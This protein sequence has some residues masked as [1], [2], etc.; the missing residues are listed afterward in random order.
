MR[1]FRDA[2]IKEKITLIVMLTAGVALLVTCASFILNDVVTIRRAKVVNLSILADIVGANCTAPLAFNDEKSATETLAA[3][4]ANQTITAACIYDKSGRPFARYARGDAAGVP[5]PDQVGKDGHHF[6][7]SALTLFEPVTLDRERIGTVFLQADLSDIQA[8]L[9]GYAGI[10]TLTLLVSLLVALLIASKLQGLISD[11]I[12]SLAQTASQ[13]STRKDYS[14][15]A[16]KQTNDEIGFLIDRFNE[17]L[18]QIQK[19]EAAL[20]AVNQQLA[21]SEQAALAATRA[22]SGFLANMSHELRTPLNAIIGFSE[23][24]VDKTFGELNTRQN[25]YV[26]NILNSGR[27]L[28]QLINDILDLAKVEAGRLELD[29]SSFSAAEALRSVEA[30]AKA[31]AG[32]KQ[33]M[34]TLEADPDLPTVTADEGKFKQIMFN[35]LSNA[36]KFTPE[37]GSVS[38]SA[39]QEG[40][41]EDGTALSQI[42]SGYVHIAV[43]DSGIGIKPEDQK[44]VFEEFEQLDASY[45][46]QQQ[47]TGLGLALTRKLVEMHGG[48]IWVESEGEGKGSTFHFTLPVEARPSPAVEETP[49]ADGAG[50]DAPSSPGDG[51][52]LVLVVED[53][54]P[55][56][57]L[58]RHYLTEAGYA[59]EQAFDGKQAL[60]MAERLQP[61]VIT[62]DIMLRKK[63]GWEVLSSLKSGPSTRNI[64]VVIVSVTEDR[65]LGIALGAVEYLVKPVQKERLIEA[66][67]RA[68]ASVNRTPSTVLVVDDEPSTVELLA[69]VLR[70]HEYTVLRAYGGQEG[71][72]IALAKVPDV[73][74]L[75]LMMPKV[76][77]F[78]VVRRLRAEPRTAEIPIVV[79]TAKDLSRDDW[80]R[81]N[82]HV[83]AVVSKS[84]KDALLAELERATRSERAVSLAGK[85]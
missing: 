24:L 16:T 83:Q 40:Q 77:G 15:R 47:G 39:V 19:H 61:Q 6:S 55:A 82:S 70:S 53:D 84:S 50:S 32:K 7:S 80:K 41:A 56:S 57:E 60:E 35:L 71:I 9:L 54:R 38:V 13:V 43:A 26:N 85:G 14:L 51:K 79:F 65:N 76:T 21:R 1:A 42:A 12:L 33:V 58:L 59:V 44:R 45:A 34:L 22:K 31:L 29:Y 68:G 8:R 73:I 27:H 63:G 64:P 23:V 3:L 17:M 36:I 69:D 49:E 62:V 11:P 74:I 20:Q 52:R 2:S 25:R 78:D 66:V 28:L 5:I 67:I 75:D 48:Q 30:V 37:G 18:A 81:L 10:A 4:R 72:E 46:R